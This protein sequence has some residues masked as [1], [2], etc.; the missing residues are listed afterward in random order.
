ML[1]GLGAA[2]EPPRKEMNL[3]RI[4]DELFPVQD[5]D[6]NYEE[7]F[8]NLMQVLANPFDLNEVTAEQL[9]SLYLLSE[10]QVNAILSYRKEA[11]LFISLYELQAVPGLDIATAGKLMPFVTV[12]TG[13]VQPSRYFRRLRH[14][15]YFL[16]RYDRMLEQKEGFSLADSA[17][18]FG[19]RPEKWYARFRSSQSGRYSF[20][21][22]VEQDPGEK[23]RWDPS[24]K[25]YG[26]D[27]WSAHVQAMNRGRLKNLV[28]GDYQVQFGQ[29]LMLGGGFGMGKGSETITTIRRSS[30]GPTPYTSVNEFGFF[31]GAAATVEISSRVWVTALVSSLGR[32]ARL[33]GEVAETSPSVASSFLT[34]GLHRNVS[35]L[36][37]RKS[38]TE[39]NAGL[40]VQ[41]KAGAFDGGV[42]MHHTGFDQPI[43]RSPTPYNQFSFRGS[44]N[45]NVGAF[46]NY[47]RGN[48]TFFSEA[49]HSL[50][51]G[52]GVTAGML[53][54]VT[55]RLEVSLL[56]R[57]FARDFYSFYSNAFSESTLP[58]NESGY[59]W[60]WKYTHP[61]KVVFSGYADLFHFPWLR[62]RAYTPSRGYE[63]L[64][65]LSWSPSPNASVFVQVREES[66]LR[67]LEGDAVTYQTGTGKKQNYWINL[68]YGTGGALSFKT[69]LQ[70]TS[71]SLGG[72]ASEGMALVQDVNAD[73]RRW[74]LSAR[75]ALF[76]AEDYD[77]RQYLYERD[78]WLAYSYPAYYGRGYRTYLV[79]SFRASEAIDLY[80]RYAY[81]RYA[82]REET[83]SGVDRI[84]GAER[85]EVK[86]Q[87]RV[88][89]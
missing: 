28:L 36:E 24:R 7:L 44:E 34:S 18:G 22:T 46:A 47:S 26:A 29:G 13:A 62:F 48:F 45:T 83:G 58:Q 68:D 71:Y 63:W 66:K 8:E 41:Y 72:D 2:Q 75:F 23:L 21:F 30:L 17:G 84:E 4:A 85:N 87:V 31:R 12:R 77:N 19:G 60:G 38:L 40:I 1:P 35:E 73:L 86:L 76:D 59:Y 51:H 69:R 32:D 80:A 3:E 81:T 25:L 27:F 10:V 53:G 9:R 6:I 79:A 89:F 49:A 15:N 42:M 67:N 56:Y 39:G 5:L 78:V 82:D 11:G 61:K 88:R 52:T 14:S 20:G 16:V 37:T 65:R 33:A 50:G 64:M 74:G 54:S 57:N 55:Q 43:N 70:F